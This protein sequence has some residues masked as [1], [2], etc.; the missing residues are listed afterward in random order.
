[1]VCFCSGY[2][3]CVD[4][5]CRFLYVTDVDWAVVKMIETFFSFFTS[6]FFSFFTV[7]IAL[8]LSVAV[9]LFLIQSFFTKSR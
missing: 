9:V 7:D 2:G 3:V 1:M 6:S 5:V 4:W 8:I